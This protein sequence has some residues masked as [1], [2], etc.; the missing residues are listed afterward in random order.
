MQHRCSCCWEHECGRESFAPALLASADDAVETYNAVVSLHSLDRSIL[1]VSPE[2]V[3][4]MLVRL[5]F[6]HREPYP[7]DLEAALDLV[8]AVES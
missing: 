7:G 3:S 4:R 6:L 1:D 2:R 8:A 5:G